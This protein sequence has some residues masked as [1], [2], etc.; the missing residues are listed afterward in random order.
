MTTRVHMCLSVRGALNWPKSE[1]KRAIGPK[2]WIKKDDD[3]PL[4]EWEL[5]HWL[6]DHLSQGHEVIPLAKECDN[7]DWKEGCKGHPEEAARVVVEGK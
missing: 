1:I 3:S 4:N 2:G 6:M 5:K 7:F